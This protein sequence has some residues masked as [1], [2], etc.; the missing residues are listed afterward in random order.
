MA[1]TDEMIEELSKLWND[2]LTT[3]EIG[4][5]LGVSK[6]AVVGKAHRLGLESRPSPIKREKKKEE[7][8]EKKSK[9]YITL[10]DLTS[11]MCRWPIGDPKDDNFH[12]CG[13][14]I[15]VG[16]VYCPH[17]SAVA[18][19]APG[20]LGK[21]SDNTEMV[22]RIENNDDDGDDKQID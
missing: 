2:G 13:K 22:D 16:G 11:R 15:P 10:M 12:F 1:W 3:V 19:V 20:K 18:Y 8:P 5:K 21:N 9:K 6:N 14:E 7:K 4:R 17:H